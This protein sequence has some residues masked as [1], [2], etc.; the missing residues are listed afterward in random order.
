MNQKAA[1]ALAAGI[2]CSVIAVFLFMIPTLFYSNDNTIDIVGGYTQL[3]ALPIAI[4][5]AGGLVYGALR[6]NT[7]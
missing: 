7:N 6:V 3:L 5:G 4:I 2:V 1:S